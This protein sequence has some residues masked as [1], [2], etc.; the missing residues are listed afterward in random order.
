MGLKLISLTIEVSEIT[1]NSA[2]LI[3]S[4]IDQADDQTDDQHG[5]SFPPM[6]VPIGGK[7]ELGGLFAEE[8][9]QSQEQSSQIIN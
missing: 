7:I 9:E 5:M 6:T 3:V 2:V 4:L 8:I 1:E